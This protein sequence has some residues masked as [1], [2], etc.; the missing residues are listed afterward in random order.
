M[1]PIKASHSS[2]LCVLAVRMEPAK[3]PN[4]ARFRATPQK[5]QLWWQ[6]DLLAPKL[7][8]EA[9]GTYSR[10]F[11]SPLCP[12]I[13]ECGARSQVKHF[14]SSCSFLQSTHT[15]KAITALPEI[16]LSKLAVNP[17]TFSLGV[18]RPPMP[19]A[20]FWLMSLCLSATAFEGTSST[21]RLGFRRDLTGQLI[22]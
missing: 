12:Y 2:L 21:K 5:W 16:S 13:I 4:S 15:S 20:P 9:D 18:S 3:T 10:L 7:C 19:V 17:V 1:L 8:L 22:C 11:P 14:L 6:P